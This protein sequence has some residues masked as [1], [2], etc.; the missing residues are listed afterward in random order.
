MKM[1]AADIDH[2]L[3]GTNPAEND[4]EDNAN[5]AGI[6]FMNHVSG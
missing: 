5:N 6:Q 2:Q 1:K 3:E 4:H